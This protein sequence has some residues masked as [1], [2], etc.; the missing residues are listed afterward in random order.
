MRKNF[1][2]INKVWIYF[3]NIFLCAIREDKFLLENLKENVFYSHNYILDMNI[4]KIQEFY[5]L[6]DKNINGFID[7]I[8]SKYTK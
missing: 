7:E 6:D 3:C 2:V 8:R 1:P 5:S 4:D